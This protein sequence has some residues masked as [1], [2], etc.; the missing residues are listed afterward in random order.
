LLTNDGTQQ[1]AESVAFWLELTGANAID[2]LSQD[3]VLGTQVAYSGSPGGGGKGGK[4]V[5]GR[6]S[7]SSIS[8]HSMCSGWLT[9]QRPLGDIV[10][11][12]GGAILQ[13]HRP[14]PLFLS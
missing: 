1:S 2:N 4:L 14:Q 5:H 11:Q 9:R 3:G 7:R 13:T 10:V 12:F 8:E 6:F